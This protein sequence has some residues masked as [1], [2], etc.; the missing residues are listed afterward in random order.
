MIN[1]EGVLTPTM[2]PTSPHGEIALTSR[3]IASW[4]GDLEADEPVLWELGIHP[5]MGT[6]SNIIRGQLA[7]R[8][9]EH[10]K[11]LMPLKGQGAFSRASLDVLEHS[12]WE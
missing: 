4:H 10:A 9:N 8:N 12:G 3:P 7:R 2:L 1:R 11:I 5:G 6:P